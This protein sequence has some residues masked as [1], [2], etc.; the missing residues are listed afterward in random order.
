[1]IKGFEGYDTS[2]PSQEVDMSKEMERAKV[3]I[4][5]REEKKALTSGAAKEGELAEPK[6]NIKGAKLGKTA[7]SRGQLSAL[8]SEAYHNRE[9]L[10]EKIAQGRRNRK[11]AGNKYGEFYL[12]VVICGC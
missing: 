11:E 5:E 9:M 6:M 12:M 8:L 4:K 7:R 3:E 1:M 2:D 10:E